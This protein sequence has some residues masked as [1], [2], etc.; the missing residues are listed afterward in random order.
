MVIAS[1]NLPFKV[2]RGFKNEIVLPGKKCCDLEDEAYSHSGM[3]VC[4]AGKED[5]LADLHTRASYAKNRDDC[6]IYN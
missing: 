6:I 3:R 4:V 5:C 2:E 1:R